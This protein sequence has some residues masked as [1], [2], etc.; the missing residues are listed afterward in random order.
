MASRRP[1]ALTAFSAPCMTR[2]ARQGWSSPV[3]RSKTHRKRHFGLFGLF[4]LFG[5][6]KWIASALRLFIGKEVAD[7]KARARK[8]GATQGHSI[9]E[10][11]HP[12]GAASF[13]KSAA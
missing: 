2:C 11:A 9:A 8:Q 1:W 5:R 4:G 13:S 10:R 12:E 3:R 6:T 7:K